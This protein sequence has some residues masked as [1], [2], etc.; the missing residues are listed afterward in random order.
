[1]ERLKAARVA[2]K[3]RFDKIHQLKMKKIEKDH[4][5]FVFDS[6]LEH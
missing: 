2:N 3:E 5:V 1:M 4:C 6:T